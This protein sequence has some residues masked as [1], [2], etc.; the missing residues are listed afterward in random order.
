MRVSVLLQ[1]TSGHF[2]L[3]AEE[4]QK[5]IEPRFL[6][7]SV[8]RPSSNWVAVKTAW[9]FLHFSPLPSLVLFWELWVKVNQTT[10]WGSI[11][12]HSHA[13]QREGPTTSVFR[14]MFC[15]DEEF[16]EDI[17]LVHVRKRAFKKVSP[18]KILLHVVLWTSSKV[19]CVSFVEQ[20][21]ESSR[22]RSRS[23]PGKWF[24]FKSGASVT[25][26]L[27]SGWACACLGELQSDMLTALVYGL[28][29]MMTCSRV[30]PA[31]EFLGPSNAS[32]SP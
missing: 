27:G 1:I 3:D 18:L 31:L 17:L 16:T 32:P 21:L 6:L 12:Q 26:T 4:P 25:E 8:L 24:R 14:L 13:F 2:S 10:W 19:K 9:F 23:V 20:I 7:C 15:G 30:C 29:A 22:G 28:P 5:W 11:Y